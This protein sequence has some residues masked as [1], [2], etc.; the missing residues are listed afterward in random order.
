MRPLHKLKRAMLMTPLFAGV[1]NT[2]TTNQWK[3]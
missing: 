3:G 2:D 1:E